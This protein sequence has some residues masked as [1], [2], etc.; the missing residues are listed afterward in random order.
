MI[1]NDHLGT[2]Q[3]MTDASGVVVWSA[4]YKPFGEDAVSPS[5]TITNNLRFPGQYYDAET[6]MHYNYY[7]TYNPPLGKFNES[8]PIG[9]RGGLNTYVY[10]ANSPIMRY[11]AL[12]LIWVTT[13]YDYPAVQ[14]HFIYLLNR[15]ARGMDTSVEPEDG[16]N[17]K[18]DVIQEWRQDPQH[19]C[20]NKEY[21]LYARRRIPQIGVLMYRAPGESVI[22]TPGTKYTIQWRPVVDSPTYSDYPSM[23]FENIFEITGSPK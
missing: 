17:T 19:P 1:H 3:K 11:D 18:R 16:A 4:D 10:A 2:S 14:N 21:P 5:S 8:D 6:G 22:Q 23:T 7:R 20:R 9:L 13:G 15:F 12:G